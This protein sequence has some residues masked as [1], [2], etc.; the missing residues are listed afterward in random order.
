MQKQEEE[1]WGIPEIE[2]GLRNF[3]ES[4]LTKLNKIAQTYANR[5][6]SEKDE[7]INEAIC[8]ILGG[9][10]TCQKEVSLM[11]FIAQTMKS[12]AFNEKRKLENIEPLDDE[13]AINLSDKA[14]FPDI[15]C[16]SHQ[17]LGQILELF[18]EDDDV[19]LYLSCLYEEF[20]PDEICEYAEWNRTKYNTVQ[21]RLRRGIDKHFPNGREK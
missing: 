19:S 20:S 17:E 13:K 10:R 9:E 4:N 1:H 6:N 2:Q 3:S 21:K 8:R 14:P 16:N 11:A 12:I 7:L 5:C 18:K 15:K